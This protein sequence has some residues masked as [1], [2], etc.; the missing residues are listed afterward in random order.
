MTAP[1]SNISDV[2]LPNVQQ[3][4]GTWNKTPTNLPWDKGF[5]ICFVSRVPS[6][7]THHVKL[8]EGIFSKTLL[9][10][11]QLWLFLEHMNLN[12]L[13]LE[14]TCE[15]TEILSSRELCWV[16]I[17]HLIST[18]DTF[19]GECLIS[20]RTFW[21]FYKKI[22]LHLNYAKQFDDMWKCWYLFYNNR[23]NF[24]S[25]E[26]GNHTLTNKLSMGAIICNCIMSEQ[27][28]WMPSNSRMYFS[29]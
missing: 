23:L 3:I 27:I 15:K 19:S 6:I 10:V 22:I 9:Y 21:I 4:F 18:V 14:G 28:K 25:I 26:H 12:S 8:T 20:H 11:F 5:N 16:I 7:E 24:N 13:E 29:K 2:F 17:E 1:V